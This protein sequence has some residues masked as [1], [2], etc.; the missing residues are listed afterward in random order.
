MKHIHTI[1]SP[2][3]QE[4]TLKFLRSDVTMTKVIFQKYSLGGGVEIYWCE[5]ILVAARLVGK[6]FL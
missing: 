5:I 2:E 6:R 3:Y 1:E 4:R